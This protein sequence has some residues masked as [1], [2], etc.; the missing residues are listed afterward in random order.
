M[1]TSS[2]Y[3][4]EALDSLRGRWFEA[5]MATVVLMFIMVLF[6]GTY[7]YPMT[8]VGASIYFLTSVWTFFVNMPLSFGYQ[9]AIRQYHL[10]QTESV[11]R[12]VISIPIKR[13]FD[14]V[15]TMFYMSV[16]VILWSFLLFIPGLVKALAYAMTPYVLYDEPELNAGEAIAKSQ[17]MMRGHKMQLF[18]LELSFIGWF[19]VC[20]VTCGV[21][22]L[23]V[24]PYYQTSIAAFYEDVKAEFEN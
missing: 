10:A 12:D 14:V 24:L 16:K 5:V 17:R 7:D 9:T 2:Q 23:W 22:L 15:W 8:R 18:K 6:A 11:A 3:R 19:L 1:K 21:G 4:Q 13:Y 20:V